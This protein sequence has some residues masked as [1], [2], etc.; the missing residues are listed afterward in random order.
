MSAFETFEIKELVDFSLW[1]IEN[2][3]I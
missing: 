1:I 3:N 2:C